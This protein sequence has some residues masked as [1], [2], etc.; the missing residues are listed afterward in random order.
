MLIPLLAHTGVPVRPHDVWTTWNLDPALLTGLFVVTALYWRGSRR[1][2]RRDRERRDRAFWTGMAAVVVALV[3][4]LEPAADAIASGHMVQHVVLVLVAAPLLARSAPSSTL[5]R[6]GP[7]AVRRVRGRVRRRV[8]GLA[9]AM[10][11]PSHPALVWLLH[12]AALWFWH[13]AGAYDAAV[14]NGWWH[15]AE[16]ASFV[17]TGV[18]FWRIVVG[19]RPARVP[20]GL[21][22]LLV[23][24]MATQSVFLS[25]LL[26]FSREAWYDVYTTSTAAWRLA[27]LADQQLAGVLMWVPA[28]AVYLALAL[29]VLVRWVRAAGPVTA[30]AHS[31]PNERE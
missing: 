26:T 5:L 10:R 7:A 3:S 20:D 8:P 22:L 14:G 2:A 17:V 29:S 6:G 12:V 4:P 15:A 31:G 13:S 18:W 30:V 21:A 23:F 16:H 25:L 27:P 24:G 19:P 28:G 9:A 11:T 1:G